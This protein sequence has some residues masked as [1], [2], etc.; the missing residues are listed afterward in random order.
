MG[1]YSRHIDLIAY[2]IQSGPGTSSV[3]PNTNYTDEEF[4]VERGRL[5]L[6]K[7]NSLFRLQKISIA[8]NI[9]AIFCHCL[10][11]FILLKCLT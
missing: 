1:S 7:E 9:Q 11:E 3:V 5:I 10:S 8:G 6:S 4:A 2:D